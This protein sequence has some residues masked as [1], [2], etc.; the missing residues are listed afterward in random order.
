MSW[1]DWYER[2]ELTRLCKLSLRYTWSLRGLCVRG[3]TFHPQGTWDLRCQDCRTP[4]SET[5]LLSDSHRHLNNTEPKISQSSKN[6]PEQ[7]QQ[8]TLRIGNTSNSTDLGSNTH[9]HILYSVS[10]THGE[11][12]PCDSRRGEACKDIISAGEV[13]DVRAGYSLTP[14]L[15]PHQHLTALSLSCRRMAGVA[16]CHLHHPTDRQDRRGGQISAF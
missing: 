1:S 11:E 4:S 9:H 12:M 13:S 5:G 14:T 15:T 7:Q 3:Y 10:L 16:R 2:C 6:E 8:N